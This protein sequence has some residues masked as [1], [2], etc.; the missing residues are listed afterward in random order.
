M[1]FGESYLQEAITKQEKLT[2]CNIEWHFIGPIQSNK[3]KLIGQ[4]FN[5]VQSLSREK[6]A[7]KLNES[8]LESQPQ[9]N[10][11]IQI[12]INNE[13]NKA[14]IKPEETLDFC[15]FVSQLPKLKLRGLMAIPQ[16]SLDIKQQQ[17]NFSQFYQLYASLKQQFNLDTL[18][19]GMSNDYQAAIKQGSNMVRI[20][21]QLFGIT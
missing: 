2:D 12:N 1:A 10:V 18:S 11:L 5:W 20:G 21:R 14:G 17:L 13:P 4:H 9:L 19:M 3:T 16:K 15:E 7:V 8:R 6:I